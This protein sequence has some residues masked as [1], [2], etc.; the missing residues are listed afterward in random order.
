MLFLF[1]DSL[2]FLNFNLSELE[3][4]AQYYRIRIEMT[5]KSWEGEIAD[6]HT[7]KWNEEDV[8]T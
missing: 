7:E 6:Y 5:S 3:F 1:F 8:F 4:R 2:W